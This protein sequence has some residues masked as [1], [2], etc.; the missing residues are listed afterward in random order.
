VAAVAELG[1]LGP[2]APVKH[3]IT[4]VM[5]FGLAFGCATSK[6]PLPPHLSRDEALLHALDY[7]KE[8]DWGIKHVWDDVTF[9]P[10]TRTW[11]IIMDT[12]RN[13]WSVSV[14]VNDKTGQVV[15]FSR[16]D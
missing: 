10:K 4:F 3:L 7:A 6:P 9:D 16:G 8:K 5:A 14:V 15:R 11:I 1:S 13:G 12:L 2:L